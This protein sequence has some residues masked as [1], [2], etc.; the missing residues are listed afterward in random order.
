MVARDSTGWT[1]EASATSTWTR[2]DGL[3]V[4]VAIVVDPATGGVQLTSYT[5]TA[6]PG[7]GLDVAATRYP[8][9]SMGRQVAELIASG[10]EPGRPQFLYVGPIRARRTTPELL[11]RVADLYRV[12]VAAG[13]PVARHVGTGMGVGDKRASDLIG[14]ARRAGLLPPSPPGRKP[15]P[16]KVT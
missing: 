3:T 15:R 4:E 13:F 5:V 6:A 7:Q 14:A 10:N 9:L 11:E 16:E 12:A 1:Y 8:V 2:D